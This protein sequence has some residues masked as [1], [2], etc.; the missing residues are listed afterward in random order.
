ML[1]APVPGHCLLVAYIHLSIRKPD[2]VLLLFCYFNRSTI[3]CTSIIVYEL[4]LI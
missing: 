2:V 4:D 3:T 1:I